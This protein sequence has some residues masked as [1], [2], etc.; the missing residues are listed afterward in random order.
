VCSYTGANSY[1]EAWSKS[2]AEGSSW[3]PAV[4]CTF[5][6][7]CAVLAYSM[8]LADTTTSLVQTAGYTVGRTPALL[9]VTSTLLLPLC[10][11]KNLSS[12][13]PFS[14]L[15]SLGMV[16]SDDCL[17]SLPLLRTQQTSVKSNNFVTVLYGYR[18]GHSVLWKSLCSWWEI[19][20]G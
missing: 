11:M 4:S 18:H 14:L 5:K 8:I 2:I 19:R 7:S 17:F 20:C 3:L 10:W 13:A 15:G 16:R 12:L 6:T 9:A 1:R